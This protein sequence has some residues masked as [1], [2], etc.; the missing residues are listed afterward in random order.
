MLLWV[1]CMMNDVNNS[2]GAF[3]EA[4]YISENLHKFILHI[5]YCWNYSAY[6]L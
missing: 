6:R 1:Y 4:E 2:R 5:A 3:E